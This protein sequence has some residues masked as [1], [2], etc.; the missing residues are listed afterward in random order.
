MID[1]NIRQKACDHTC[2]LAIKCRSGLGGF[3]QVGDGVHGGLRFD[4][5]QYRL[6]P[7]LVLVR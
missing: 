2:L 4:R 7:G 3:G 5:I 6:Q 1:L